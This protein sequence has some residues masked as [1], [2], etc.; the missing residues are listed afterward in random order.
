MSL[1]LS[2]SGARGIV[3]ED[4][5]PCFLNDLLLA[6]HRFIPSG[7]VLLGGDTRSSG[8]PISHIIEGILRMLGRNIIF[9]G[10]LPTPTICLATKH[11]N[12]AGGIVVT[13]SHNP[14]RWN[15]I[16][17]VG[18]DGLF[19]PHKFWQDFSDNKFDEPD[20]VPYDKIGGKQLN[21]DCARTHIE[22]VMS[23]P[24][25]DPLA[26]R[27][28]NLR[29]AYDG[30]GGAGPAVMI[31]LFQILGVEYSAIG[32]GMDGNF[33]HSPEPIPENLDMLSDL[34]VHYG[35]DIGFANDP[36]AD[37]LAI[38]DENGKPIG[39]EFTL[40]L[41]AYRML[42]YEPS[43]VVV[44]LSTSTLIDFIAEKFGGK[45]HRTSVGEYWVTKKI[46]ELGAAIGGE[47]NGGVIVPDVHPARDSITAVSL[48]C[49]L[50]AESGKKV[51]QIVAEFPKKYMVKD[52]IPFSGNFSKISDAIL[53]DFSPDEK[54]LTDGIWFRT[55]GGFVHIRPSNTEPVLRIIVED[56]DEKIARNLVD[57]AKSII[58]KHI[59]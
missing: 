13:A 37:R 29:I 58:D 53:N 20:F 21:Y 41:A 48:I 11:F 38:V 15:G 44:N 47:G 28:A 1:H 22:K 7:D 8:E 54:I 39:E 32:I 31:Q 4:I 46:L 9:A 16:K 2:I 5:N 30:V 6:F 45:V 33:I 52:K 12:C 10:K 26:I 57:R 55:D 18:S 49:S 36:D 43:D 59:R 19:L 40:A 50:L 17:L 35:A 23:L 51:S 3:G 42:S 34:V 27:S 14:A 56:S 24:F 25:V